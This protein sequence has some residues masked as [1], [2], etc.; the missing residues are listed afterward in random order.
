[1]RTKFLDKTVGPGHSNRRVITVFIWVLILLWVALVV[2]LPTSNWADA[3]QTDAHRICEDMG[4]PYEIV[5]AIVRVESEG[6]PYVLNVA[7]RSV[8]KVYRFDHAETAQVFLTEALKLTDRIDIGLMQVHWAV[9]KKVY[10]VDATALLDVSTNLTIGCD[11]LRRELA[12]DGPLWQRIG[13][14]HSQTPA[15]NERYALKVLYA[16]L[17]PK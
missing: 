3:W 17:Y 4:V 6:H 9:W 11:I 1:M 12:G 5:Q 7:I 8:W 16:A 13:R 2:I 15:R 10:R 14:Y